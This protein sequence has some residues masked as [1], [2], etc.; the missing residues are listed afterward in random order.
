[1]P[2]VPSVS[3]PHGTLSLPAFF[4]DATRAAVR[5]LD[6][7]DLS[8]CGVEGLVVNTFHLLSHPGS[9]VIRAHGGVHGFMNWPGQIVCDSGGFQVFSL[10]EHNPAFGSVTKRGF[11]YRHDLCADKTILTPVKSIRKQFQFGADIMVCLD[12]CTGLNATADKQR[13][14]VELTVLWAEKCKREF[15]RQLEQSDRY[16]KRP[17]LL[18]A[19]IQGG[20]SADLRRECAQRLIEIGFDGYAFGGWPIDRANRLSEALKWVAELVPAPCPAYAMGIGKPENVVA[21]ARM[22][23]GLFDCVIPTR[24]ARHKRLFAFSRDPQTSGLTG[25]DFYHCL[26]IQDKKYIADTNP[27]EPT[28]DCLCCRNYSRAYLR[29][30]FEVRDTLAGRLATIHNLR[31]YSR[32]IQALSAE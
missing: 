30:L 10:L 6:A 14:S 13:E 23:Y 7:N 22:G 28:C 17:P 15:N 29:H 26:Y 20:S 21:C 8:V 25:T 11:A 1:M 2:S 27:V 18:F 4:P 16:G 24:D 32:L 5:S 9:R 12:Y 31:F 3:T 19:V